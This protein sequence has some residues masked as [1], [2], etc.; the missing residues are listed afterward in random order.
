MARL[1]KTF[2]PNAQLNQDYPTYKLNKKDL[3]KNDF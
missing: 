3:T 2:G 1:G